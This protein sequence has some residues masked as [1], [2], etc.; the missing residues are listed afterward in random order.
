MGAPGGAG[1]VTRAGVGGCVAA[2]RLVAVAAGT[3]AESAAVG[4]GAAESTVGLPP[5][6]TPTEPSGVG[7]TPEVAQPIVATIRQR[8]ANQ[9]EISSGRRRP[10]SRAIDP[11]TIASPGTYLRIIRSNPGKKDASC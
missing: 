6:S 9:P 1:V 2:G 4:E 11:D 5:G 3:A 8:T 10:C 7:A